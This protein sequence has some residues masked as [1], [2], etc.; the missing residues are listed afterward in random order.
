MFT[1][2]GF[3]YM[4]LVACLRN[5]LLSVHSM[6]I[7][8]PLPPPVNQRDGTMFTSTW[9]INLSKT[10]IS[11]YVDVAILASISFFSAIIVS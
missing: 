5:H 1:N 4:S 2:Q 3:T 7:I 11:L 8:H 9:A 6:V 10:P